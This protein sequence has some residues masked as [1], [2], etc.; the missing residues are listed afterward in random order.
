LWRFGAL[1][2]EPLWRSGQCCIEGGLAG[3][4]DCVGLPEVDLIRGHQAD[5]CVVMVFVVPGE[6]KAAEGGCPVDGLEPSGELRSMFQ[7]LEAGLREGVG[8][9]GMR[10]A[11]RS[12]HAGT[13]GQQGRR[14]YPSSGCHDLHAASVGRAARR[15][16]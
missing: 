7:R 11:V 13:G 10:S 3:G 5:T 14:A 16:S 8:I 15:V 1:S 6:E 2:D 4:V 9:R 12:D